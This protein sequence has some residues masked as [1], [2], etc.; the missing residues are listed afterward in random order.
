VEDAVNERVDDGYDYFF[1]EEFFSGHANGFL[2]DGFATVHLVIVSAEHGG[3][4]I[5]E[6][7]LLE[8][9]S[10]FGQRHG[11]YGKEES[12]H[13]TDYEGGGAF[14]GPAEWRTSDLGKMNL[15]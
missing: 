11:E 14:A 10:Y 1:C 12:D 2:L 15:Q 9:A 13:A 8:S 7:D 6:E 4:L 5:A 3:G